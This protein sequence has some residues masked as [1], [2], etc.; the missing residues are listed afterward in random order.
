[1]MPL[2]YLAKKVIGKVLVGL[3]CDLL[4]KTGFSCVEHYNNYLQA[5][6]QLPM[7]TME[8]IRMRYFKFSC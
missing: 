1:M 2:L 7:K 5:E 6:M 4:Y 3:T 8:V